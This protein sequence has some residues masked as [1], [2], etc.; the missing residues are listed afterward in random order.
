MDV[1]ICMS[2]SGRVQERGLHE[3]KEKSVRRC[4]RLR[5]IQSLALG[6]WRCCS[7]PCAVWTLAHSHHSHH[8]HLMLTRIPLALCA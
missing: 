4:R 2:T 7:S 5:I 6:P 8:S 3:A 1:R